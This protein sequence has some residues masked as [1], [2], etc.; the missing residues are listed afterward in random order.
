MSGNPISAC[1]YCAA[2]LHFSVVDLGAQPFSNSYPRPHEIDRERRYP[3]HVRLCTNCLL[4]QTDFDAL[5]EAIFSA[6]YAY[7]SS[8]SATWVA[9]ARDYA[10]AMIARY[11][12]GKDS[13]VVEVAS[14]DGY[15]LQHFL[16][17]SVPCLGVEPTQGTA[18][19][20]MAK[21]VPTEI[22]FFGEKTAR[23][24]VARGYA[25]DLMAANNVLAHVPDIADFVRGFTVLLKREGVATF[26]FPH[27]LE[28]F[29]RHAF[30]TI[31][32]EHYFYLSLH[33]VDRIFLKCGL[34]I[35][36]IERLSTHGGSLRAFACRSAAA[37]REMPSVADIRREEREAGL[38]CASGYG[39]LELSVA[40]IKSG[41]RSFLDAALSR[42]KSVAAIGAAAKGST[43]LNTCDL[44]TEDIAF[45]ADV[46]SRKQGRVMPGSHI[47]IVAPEEL[48][49]R[50]PDYVLIL[51]WN[52]KTEIMDQ[53]ADIRRWGGHFVAA[54]P[55]LEVIS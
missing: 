29:R 52:L 47:P 30:D 14:N 38:A 50:R 48:R 27:L 15:L 28:L 10:A 9:H 20:A 31:Y 34:R 12:L 5:P 26:E 13:M 6:E 40:N 45:V 16:S 17:S 11:G 24:L 54:I 23:N 33:A 39:G 55:Q 7:F 8:Y 44:T 35:F 37:H 49:A 42:G 36:D 32:H 53:L 21:G 51:P 43:F 1:R 4:A 3:L 25:A 2:P 22:A 19:V 41:I 18:S 46:N